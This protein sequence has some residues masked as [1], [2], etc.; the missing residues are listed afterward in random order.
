M[1][2]PLPGQRCE[3]DLVHR[4]AAGVNATGGFEMHTDCFTEEEEKAFVTWGKCVCFSCFVS[5]FVRALLR[6]IE[7]YQRLT[8]DNGTNIYTVFA[9]FDGGRAGVIGKPTFSDQHDEYLHTTRHTTHDSPSHT[10]S[11]CTL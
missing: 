11:A 3:K 1:T 9:R 5:C 4:D 10:H 6:S 8:H 7:T 2:T